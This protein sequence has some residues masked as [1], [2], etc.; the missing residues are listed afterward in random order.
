MSDEVAMSPGA[1]TRFWFEE[2]PEKSWFEK[3]DA[4][5]ETLRRRFGGAVEKALAGRLDTW[6]QTPRGGA[7]LILLL[8][9]FTR[10]IFRGTPRAFAGDAP[11][12][13]VARAMIARKD[14][15]RLPLRWRMF[16]YLPLE[17]SEDLADQQACL[18]LVRNRIGDAEYVK[19]AQAHL[20]IVA[21]FGRFPHRNAILGRE[22]TPEEEAF[23]AQP[24]SSF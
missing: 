3:N 21:R 17:H 9:Q 23:L 4:F 24:G 12:R 7:A 1:V 14:D 5:D 15:L 2:I 6:R 22:S 11:A 8:D 20:D 19:Y 10:N 16:L 18:D 13:D